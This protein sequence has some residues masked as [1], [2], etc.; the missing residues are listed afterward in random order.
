[1]NLYLISTFQR[2]GD[3]LIKPSEYLRSLSSKPSSANSTASGG[4]IPDPMGSE[5]SGKEDF[6]C[7]LSLKGIF[8]V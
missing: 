2:E 4:T 1:M 8:H 5:E 6:L 3:S 7:V